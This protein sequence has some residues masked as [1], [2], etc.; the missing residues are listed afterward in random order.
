MVGPS[1]VAVDHL[2][3]QQSWSQITGPLAV[4]G[5]AGSWEVGNSD[6]HLLTGPVMVALAVAVV[7]TNLWSPRWQLQLMPAPGAS[8]DGALPHVSAWRKKKPYGRPTPFLMCPTAMVFC[9]S[10]GPKPLSGLLSCGVLHPSPLRLSSYSQPQ[11]SSHGLTSKDQASVPNP[12]LPQWVS[13]Q[14]FQA[15]K[16]CSALTLCAG[17]S[18]L[19]PPHLLLHSPLRLQSSTSVP[20]SEGTS[21]C[22]ETFPLSQ[23]PPSG[24]DPIPI[25][26]FFIIFFF[27]LLPYTVMW[28]FSC[29]FGSLRSSA[30]IQ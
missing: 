7:S 15:G 9:L 12:H 30:S 3:S 29:P 1:S 18:S 13:R 20:A 2:P 23:L 22:M 6:L 14:A 4:V 28:K 26:F 19:C 8:V 27:F 17:F 16:C 5:N 11:T 24:T 10:G 25:L 21:Q